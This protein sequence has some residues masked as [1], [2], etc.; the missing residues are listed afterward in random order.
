MYL[1]IDQA[2]GINQSLAMK[3][4][5][6]EHARINL[7]MNDDLRLMHIFHLYFYLLLNDFEDADDDY[8]DYKM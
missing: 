4:M 8:S 6:M 2:V 3:M 7:N 1:T 5:M